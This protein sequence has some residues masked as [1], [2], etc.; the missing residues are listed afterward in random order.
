MDMDVK[1]M[2][3]GKVDVKKDVK[4]KPD[5]APA[6]AKPALDNKPSVESKPA[7]KPAKTTTPAAKG[8]R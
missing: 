8:N 5:T 1:K 4:A 6:K 7:M 2:P 3:D